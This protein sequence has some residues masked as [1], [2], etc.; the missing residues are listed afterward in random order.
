MNMFK[1]FRYIFV[2]FLFVSVVLIGRPVSAQVY[3]PDVTFKDS[4]IQLLYQYGREVYY[5]GVDPQEASFVFQRI[6][7]LDCNHD[8][9]Q[10]FLSKI[11]DKYPNISIRIH[12]CSDVQKVM[13][14]LDSTDDSARAEDVRATSLSDQPSVVD[15]TRYAPMDLSADNA[16]APHHH[17]TPIMA[18]SEP[19]LEEFSTQE[20]VLLTADDAV[21]S[22]I[23][24]PQQTNNNQPDEMLSNAPK[25]YV[26]GLSADCEQL[27]ISHQKLQNEI[28]GFEAQIKTKDQMI[29]TYQ[30]QIASYQTRDGASYASIAQDQ[31]DLIR[32]QQGNIDY[33][34]KELDEAKEQIA[35][36]RFETNP[37]Y[38][39]MHR[40][41]AKSQ[42]MAKE[43]E[44]N[45]EAKN[46]EAQQLQ[47]QL[48]EL[49]EQ[50]QLVKKILSEKNDIIKSLEE[51]LGFAKL[52]SESNF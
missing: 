38:D 21:S 43:K 5:R 14:S 9:A 35:T 28:A 46:R 3:Y 12:G 47:K 11:Q 6:L 26:S 36:N 50:V 42:L 25:S 10:E 17:A 19:I 31:K 45:L 30:R 49:Q 20:P 44:M 33:L 51:Q 15:A 18:Y 41:I 48:G 8:G 52:E 37:A 13:L 32:I 40:E 39:A 16:V 7:A 23:I 1:C 22:S 2:C 4:L 24:G 34:Q 29:T 27:K